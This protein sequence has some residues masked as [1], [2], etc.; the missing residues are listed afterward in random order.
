M[1]G[2]TPEKN[3]RRYEGRRI[4]K[5]RQGRRRWTRPASAS[6]RGSPYCFALRSFRFAPQFFPL[7]LGNV[8]DRCLP[9]ELQRANIRNAGPAVARTDPV[10]E[11]VHHAEAIR[12][13]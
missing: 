9:A 5:W 2:D 6:L 13:Q 3:L 11:G 7:R 1:Q 12:T 10:P 4:R 8:I